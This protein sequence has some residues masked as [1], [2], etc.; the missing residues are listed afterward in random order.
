MRA[1]T[2]KPGWYIRRGL[3]VPMQVMLHRLE[4]VRRKERTHEQVGHIVIQYE[5]LRLR[6]G[7]RA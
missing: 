5:P 6:H 2:R 7:R 3:A 1:A 4:M